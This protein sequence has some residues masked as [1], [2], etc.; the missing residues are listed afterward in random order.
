M[1]ALSRWAKNTRLTDG[2]S[3]DLF[4]LATIAGFPILPLWLI[5]TGPGL[6]RAKS[7][8]NGLQTRNDR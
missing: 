1:F 7:P 8:F 3:G 6:L 4:S 5:V 2:R